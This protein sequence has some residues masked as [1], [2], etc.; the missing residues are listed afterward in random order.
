M[1]TTYWLTNAFSALE[2]PEN[3]EMKIARVHSHV[4]LIK[5]IRTVIQIP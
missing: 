3:R 4:I 1:V 5:G 2:G